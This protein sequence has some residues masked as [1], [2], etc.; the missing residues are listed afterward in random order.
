MM[1]KRHLLLRV[2]RM[3]VEVQHLCRIPSF[4]A[5]LPTN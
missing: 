1:P 2:A 3:T 4:P 5:N